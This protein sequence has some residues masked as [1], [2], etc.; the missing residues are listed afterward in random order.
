MDTPPISKQ[1][2]LTQKLAAEF[3]GGSKPLSVNTLAKWRREGTGPRFLRVGK[4]IR[5][6]VSDLLA[7]MEGRA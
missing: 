2:A 5:Y 7:F 6:R 3:L 4:S 1:E